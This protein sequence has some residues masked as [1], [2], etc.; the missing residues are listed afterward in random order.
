MRKFGLIGCPLKHSFS[1]RYFSQKFQDEH[2]T[3]CQYD[4]FE[5]DNID[6]II[7]VLENN[8]ELVGLNI[9]IPYK[10]QVIP[11]LD[12]LEPG[13]KAIGAVN[14]IKVTGDKLVGYNTDYIGFKQSLSTWLPSEPVK[15]LVLGTGGASR[16]VKQALVDLAIP[17]LMISRNPSKQEEGVSYEELAQASEIFGT[18]H[19]IINTT[20]LG[21]YPKIDEM[22]DIPF[23]FLSAKHMVYDLVYNPEET[24]LMKTVRQAGGMAKN[25]LEMLHLQAEA[26]WEIWNRD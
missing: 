1:K 9:T 26:S 21:T 20:P 25:G 24:L 11:Y 17:F 13:C 6:K 14:T 22:P 12:E 2:L 10:E 7:V 4:L 8:P 5:I 3:D 18:H 16:A 15:A 19:L 23:S